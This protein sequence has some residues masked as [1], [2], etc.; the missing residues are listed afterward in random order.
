MSEE[1]NTVNESA[2]N[3][4]ITQEVAPTEAGTIENGP[5]LAT[6]EG[7]DPDK[8][9]Q[10]AVQER[11]NKVTAKRYEAERATKTA[12]EERDAL[13]ARLDS[14]EAAKPAPTVSDLPDRFDS[15]DEEFNAAVIRRDNERQALADHNATITARQNIQQQQA[16]QVEKDRLD[17]VAKAGDE[18]FKRATAFGIS[19]DQLNAAAMKI[20]AIGI[21]PTV[22]EFILDL[23]DG[24][25]ILQHLAANPNDHYALN[26]LNPMM[27][28]Q[29]ITGS[30]RQKAEALKPKQ[31]NAPDPVVPLSGNGVDP[32]AGKYANLKGAT[33]S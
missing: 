17:R 33:F 7:A 1:L 21:D 23:E 10:D 29:M 18:C 24:P 12:K 26:G 14:I 5:E 15:S 9:N 32:E 19:Q 27:A 31:S 25:L 3:E 13:Q 2:P 11:I 28:S 22:G 4:L 6:G 16:Q 8:I 30:L 20:Q